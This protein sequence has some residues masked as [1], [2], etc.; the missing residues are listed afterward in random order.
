VVRR[1]LSLLRGDLRADAERVLGHLTGHPDPQI[2][3]AAL[4]ASSRTG[5]HAERLTAALSDPEPQVR[6]AAV[7]GLLTCADHSVFGALAALQVGTIEE[8]IALAQAIGRAPHERFRS[9]L[10]ALVASREPAIVREVLYVWEQAPEL[11]DVQRLLRLLEN[12][13]VRGDARRVFIAGGQRFFPELLVALDDPRTPLGVRRHLPRTISRYATP[14]AAAALTA[15]L[16]REPDGMTEFKI[17]RAL[18]R[19]RADA[20]LLAIDPEPVRLYVRRATEDAVRYARLAEQLASSHP[21]DTI[22]SGAV[23]LGEL[24]GEKRAAALERVFRA[25]GVLHPSA[26]LRSVH[27]AI[28]SDD[29]ERSTAAR[30]ILEDLLP[31]SI[32][33]PLLEV[34]D[35]MTGSGMTTRRTYAEVLTALLEDPSDS[36]RCIAAHHVAERRIVALRPQLVRLRPSSP[37]VCQAFTQAIARLDA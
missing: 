1:A 18:G 27:D 11:G 35:P 15:R 31:A 29:E 8:R 23:L 10:D 6:A 36:L 34:I 20:P 16:V 32:R 17:L 33:Y 7:I 3:A 5:C 24:L 28:L 4:A 26:D 21:D 30:E 2:R 9:V 12:P 13:H 25:L 19:M 14:A 37:V 22:E